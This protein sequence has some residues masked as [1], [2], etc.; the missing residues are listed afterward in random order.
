MGGSK[1]AEGYG[2]LS[3]WAN[4]PGPRTFGKRGTAA[5]TVPVMNETPFFDFPPS[6]KP[7][8][9]QQ[10]V[11]EL[12]GLDLT[13]LT[14]ATPDGLTLEPYYA[15]EDLEG[16]PVAAIGATQKSVPGWENRVSIAETEERIANERA[17]EALAS[18]ADGVT[19]SIEKPDADLARLL[20][21][22]KLSDTP[23]SFRLGTGVE[24]LRFLET[25]RR[26]TGYPPKGSL[27]AAEVPVAEVLRLMVDAPA[28]RP[29]PISEPDGNPV[30]EAL[31]A[32]LRQTVGYLD[33][34]TEAGFPPEAVFS[35]LEFSLSTSSDYFLN[36]AKVRALRF[37]L[38]QVQRGYPIAKPV[39]VFIH[40]TVSET[41]TPE[42]SPEAEDLVRATL[43]AL[44]VLAAGCD[45]VTV[46][47]RPLASVGTSARL[48][49]NLPLILKEEAYLAAVADPA[50]GSY[51]L[52]TLTW[53][54]AR[55]AWALFLENTR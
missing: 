45:A 49:R 48:S 34:T 6:P 27:L 21:G 32:V 23:A 25:L 52:E 33:A 54:L 7:R 1:F 5:G 16:I 18:G 35:K 20:N 29:L 46:E 14:L 22:L 41:G 31:A 4:A 15:A 55:A 36:L 10:A 37:L 44:A 30:P 19:F 24:P 42:R 50:A 28:F 51:F 40:A 9:Q 12:K 8:W 11:R 43:Q 17:R 53:S 3:V 39:P 47:A 13:A 38:A 2:H 26:V